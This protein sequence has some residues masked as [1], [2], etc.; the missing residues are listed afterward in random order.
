MNRD[1]LLI[2][3]DMEVN[4]AILRS[5]FEQEYNLLEAEN[6][7]QAMMLIQQYR[8]SLAAVLLDVVMPVKDGYQVMA[9]MVQNRLITSIPVI[10]I[11]SED[12]MENEV[13]AFDLG[14]SD[15]I[16]KPFEPHVVRRRVQNAVELNRHKMHLEEMVEEQAAK[17]RESR[18]V[19][20]DTLSSIIEHRSLETG[21]HVLRIRMF[22]KL[23]LEDV[24]C[25][26]PEYELNERAIGVIAE[27]AALHDI[28]KISIPD[29]ILNKPGRLTPEE[30]EVMKAHTVRGCEILSGLDRMGDKEYLEYAYNICRYHHE[31]WDGRGYPDGLIGDNTPVCAQ[32]AG[33][34]D[35]YDA[36]T[37]DRVYKKAIPPE[38]AL[39]MILN[40]E[41]GAFSPKLLECLKNVREQFFELTHKYADGH[42]PKTDSMGSAVPFSSSVADVENTQE[43]EQKKYFAMLRYTE[44]TVM[45]VDMDS[46]IYHLVYQENEDF[47]DLRSGSTFEESIREFAEHSVFPEDRQTVL[48]VLDSYIEDFFNRGLIKRSRSYRV[49]HR[50]SGEYLWYEATALRVDIDNPRRHKV[51]IIWRQQKRNPETALSLQNDEFSGPTTDDLIVGVKQCLND[52]WFTMTYVNEGFIALFGYSREEIEEKFHNSYIEMIHPDDR[53]SVRRQFLDQLSSGNIQELEYRIVTKNGLTLW[54]LEKCQMVNRGDGCECIN[55][56]LTDITNIK[57]SQEE[58]NMTMEC[59]RTIQ[60]QTNDIIFEADLE[61][62]DVSYSPNWEKRFGYRPISQNIFEQIQTV[63]HLLPEDIPSFMEL[64]KKIASG[65]PYGEVEVRIANSEG[66]Y[67]WC[68]IRATTQFNDAGKPVR[69]VG[70]ILDIDVEKR[71]TQELSDKAQRDALTGLYNKNTERE[72]IQRRLDRREQPERAAMLIID[73]DNFK[74]VNDSHGHMFG[75]AVLAEAAFRLKELFRTSDI[76]ARFGGD[77]FLVFLQYNSDGKFLY[78]KAS[79]IIETFG[80]VYSGDLQDF[81]LTCSIGI[82]LCPE[83]GEDFQNLFQRCDRALYYA[84][85]RG[86]NRYAVY[87]GRTMSKSFGLNSEQFFAASTKIESDDAEDFS[88]DS[89]VPQAFE[90]LYESGDI[91]TAVNAILDMVGHRYNVSRV[92][93][94]EDSEDGT[95]CTNTF[96]WCNEGVKPEIENLQNITYDSLGGNYHDNFNENG[97]FYCQDISTLPKEQYDL[98]ASQGIRSVLQ[99]AVRD[100]GKSVGFVGF[101]DCTILRMWTQNQIDAL[102]FIAELLS[103]FLLKKRAQDRALAVVRDLRMILD[104]QN[105]WI[106]V[107][108]PDSYAL[109]CINAKTLRTVPDVRLGARCY[110]AFFHRNSPCERCPAQDI[111]KTANRT[112]EVYNPILN[113]WSLADACMIRWGDE[114]ACLLACHDI[115]CYKVPSEVSKPGETKGESGEAL[116]EGKT[117]GE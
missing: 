99:C 19:I 81:S 46:G 28:G 30:F 1:T 25:Y 85:L 40:G 50:V 79:K 80:N 90:K 4:R 101:D 105:S 32:A 27:A 62:G 7:E 22:T 58:L 114:D 57:R 2:V 94:F 49:L 37:T 64:T 68:R 98:L 95:H 106:Y 21:Q 112:L 109:R 66:K 33:I 47:Q 77:E 76:V 78:E 12:S 3:D 117:D 116:E 26:C 60:D 82:S 115:T 87:D 24:M 75:D 43:L 53:L 83:D 92:Y 11:T 15:I 71:R 56:V 18:D 8:N 93:I 29:T 9:D 69:A 96:E 10:V 54:I 44:S 84:K 6:G 55:C 70:V 31:R 88:T 97:I 110:E 89:I 63:S 38:R 36:L 51:L 102:T 61:K 48:A 65:E 23:L 113:V 108:D 5:L 52:R 111:R 67:L 45:E 39:T 42:S 86:K 104:N 34:A 13:R 20:M 35:A 73:L 16:I 107:I 59:Y 103:T 14:A 91:E 100:G 74:Q 41:C 17:L 72:K